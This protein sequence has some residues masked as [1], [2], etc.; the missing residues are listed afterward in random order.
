MLESVRLSIVNSTC[1]D[2]L[3]KVLV[4]VNEVLLEYLLYGCWKLLKSFWIWFW[5]LGKNN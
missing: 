1:L 4:L 2:M 5:H 3:I